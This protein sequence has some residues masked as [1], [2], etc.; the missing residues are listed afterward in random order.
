MCKRLA[1]CPPLSYGS[2]HSVVNCR[3]FWRDNNKHGLMP[4]TK[5]SGGEQR[6]V[7][8]KGKAT[9]LGAYMRATSSDRL[10]SFESGAEVTVP[11]ISPQFALL[12]TRVNGVRNS[13]ALSRLAKP[14]VTVYKSRPRG[15]GAIVF[16]PVF[17]HHLGCR[18]GLC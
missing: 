5:I 10:C 8:F 2:Y 6:V 9:R 18:R 4:Q 7:E 12:I 3:V 1:K 13:G 17:Y 14:S 11:Q 16:P 15:P